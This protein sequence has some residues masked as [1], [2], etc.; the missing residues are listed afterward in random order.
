MIPVLEPQSSIVPP[1]ALHLEHSILWTPLADH[2]IVRKTLRDG[3][4]GELLAMGVG[5]APD[6]RD[7]DDLVRTMAECFWSD[8]R[9]IHS[10]YIAGDPF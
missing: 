5:S 8:M 6:F 4:H 7:L 10:T 9:V 2:S 1:Q 3:K